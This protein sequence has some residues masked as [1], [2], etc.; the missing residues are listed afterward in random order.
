MKKKLWLRFLWELIWTAS[1]LVV[2]WRHAHWSVFM[3]LTVLSLRAMLE[4]ATRRLKKMSDVEV[5]KELSALEARLGV[6]R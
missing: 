4:D 3:L 5:D 2:V 1:L 6:K